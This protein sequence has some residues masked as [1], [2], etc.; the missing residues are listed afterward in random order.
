MKKYQIRW[1][2]MVGLLF[3][4]FTWRAQPALGA[5]W[6]SSQST[7]LLIRPILP[8]DNLGGTKLG[9]F[10][11]KTK[12]QGQTIKVHAFNPTNQPL[13]VK[14]KLVTAGTLDNGTVDYSGQSKIDRQ[15]LP[16]PG[17]NYLKVARQTV[18]PAKTGVDLSVVVQPFHFSGVKANALKITTTTPQTQNNIQ[19]QY[20]YGIAIV[21]NGQPL[22]KPKQIKLVATQVTPRLINQQ[23][24]LLQVRLANQRAAYIHRSRVQVT[25]QNQRWR[26]IHYTKTRS[27]VSVAPNTAFN[28][29]LPL[30]GKRLVPGTYRLKVKVNGQVQPQQIVKITAQAARLINQQNT[31]YQ[32]RR[33]R[34]LIGAVSLVVVSGLILFSVRH[35]VNVKLCTTKKERP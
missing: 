18:I 33:Q 19:N 16:N 30:A 29:Q 35:Q 1:W 32:K 4:G 25:L 15:L 12:Q 2:L 6:A 34:Y 24:A 10:N 28:D 8:A 3:F 22:A 27:A 13:T 5:T 21:L 14:T 26:F 11:L 23:H 31:A 7:A 9:Y 20:V 17:T